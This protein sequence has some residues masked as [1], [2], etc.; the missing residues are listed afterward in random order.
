MKDTGTIA[1][2]NDVKKNSVDM[3]DAPNGIGSGANDSGIPCE[4]SRSDR[5]RQHPAIADQDEADQ[6]AVFEM[7]HASHKI[8]ILP[9]D[10]MTT[11]SSTS[12]AKSGRLWCG[13][14]WPPRKFELAVGL[15]AAVVIGSLV[16]LVLSFKNGEH[17]DRPVWIQT[18]T[19]LIF[20][21]MGFHHVSK[22]RNEPQRVVLPF[23]T[24]DIVQTAPMAP[25]SVTE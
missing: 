22:K 1:L 16:D 8:M 10:V 23:N 14:H 3:A 24:S 17:F 25:V 5:L 12:D 6:R 7:L 11:S 20:T 15:T 18:A 9:T 2:D 13:L 4:P 19:L 21:T